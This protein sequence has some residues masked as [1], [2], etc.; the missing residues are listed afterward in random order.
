MDCAG[1]TLQD[2]EEYLRRFR[3]RVVRRRIPVSGSIELTHRCNLKCLHCY[4]GPQS[5]LRK[6]K[7]RE[8]G[9]DRFLSILDE[10]TE[11]GC[12]FLLI[13]GGDP[14]IRNDFPEIYRRAKEKGLMVTVFTNGALISDGIAG[15]FEDLPPHAVEISLYGATAATYEK[16]TRSRGSF[17]RC[18]N[19]IERLLRHGINV[20]LKTILMTLNSHEFLAMKMMADVYGVKFRFDPAISPCLN[21]DKAPLALRV[22]PEEAVEKEFSDGSRLEGWL[23]YLEKNSGS[24]LQGT[25]YNCGAGITNFHIDPYGNLHPCLMTASPAYDLSEGGFSEGWRDEMP[26]IRE[27]KVKDDYICNRCEQR[28]FC[29]FCPPFFELEKDGGEIYSEYHCAMGRERSRVIRTVLA[30]R[31]GV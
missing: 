11:A 16:I 4:L 26:R 19:G 6:M 30:D 29:G 5:L 10:I 8:L 13:T 21:G 1:T 23:R 17:G 27:I 14:L 9:T 18:I 12:L 22:S 20:K 7:E 24:P 31:G 28:D 3:E 2:N 15:L 25:L